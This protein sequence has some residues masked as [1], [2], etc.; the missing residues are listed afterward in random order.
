[1]KDLKIIFVNE[2]TATQ[3]IISDVFTFS[4]MFGGFFINHYLLGSSWFLDAFFAIM[5][6]LLVGGHHAR[7]RQEMSPPEALEYL[8]MMK[9]NTG[10]DKEEG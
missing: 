5:I 6:L 10:A 1:M 2:K 7:N 8:T 3:S 4:G 9:A